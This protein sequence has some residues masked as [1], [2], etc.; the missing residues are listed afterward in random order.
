MGYPSLQACVADLRRHGMLTVIDTP[1]DPDQE[2]AAILRRVYRAGGPALLFTHARGCRFPL[3][4]NLYGTMER[5]RFLFRDAVE[6]V[7]QLVEMRGDPGALL[8]RPLSAW[9]AIPAA[10]HALPLP[11]PTRRAPVLA[12][13]GR[14]SDLPRVRT[15]PRD[16]GAFITLPAVY[17]EDPD[18]RGWMRSNLG[19]YRVQ[20]D[21]GVYAP[22][23][24]V[25]MHYQIHRGIG[26]HHAHAIRRGE[27]LRVHIYAGGPPSL[28]VSAVMPLPEGLPEIAFAGALGG[29]N[30]RISQLPN[31]SRGA[32]P[33]LADA[34]FLI[35]GTIDPTR[36]LPEGPFGDHLG[37]YSLVHDF[38]VMEVEAVYHRADA[39]WPF[40]SV[41]R[42]P[43]ED[44]TFGQF[45]H[46][47]T[48]AAIPAVLP[49]VKSVH[50]VDAAGVHPLL[51]VLGSERY[52]PYLERRAPQELLTQACAVLGQ[53]QLS[54]AKYVLIAAH[55]D[56]PDL[57]PHDVRR[58]LGHV[59]ARFDPRRDLHFHTRTTI[60]TLDYTGGALNQ[61]SKLVIA[62]AGPPLRTLGDTL[63]TALSLPDGFGDARLCVP[64]VIAVR[65]PR[66][67]DPHRA[68]DRVAADVD[69]LCANLPP[70]P[71]HPLV[72]LVDDPDFVSAHLDNLLWTVFT[73]SNPAADVHGRNAAVVQKHWGCEGPL[74]IDAR[75]RPH[76]A[77]A[78]EEDPEAAERVERLARSGGPL[79]GLW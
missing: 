27:K 26:V 11:V 7:T 64:G 69:A 17:T 25:G 6:G 65:G 72:V 54:L 58:F 36:T 37:Y 56:A 46:A 8:R 23:R 32:L 3:L 34:D 71:D 30:L 24:E 29:R 31:A 38:P 20:L 61:G 16:G 13:R 52:T 60:D 53:G 12:R 28:A 51:L 41:G 9:R 59:L 47:L 76:H 19:M 35:V 68:K 10:M 78:L 66:A 14:L 63:P 4:T 43:Q 50:A 57:D 40:T 5:A 39:I 1:V 22:E 67:D 77:P 75:A 44:T 42:P 48:G 15:W 45:V 74:V 79:H 73:R 2:V 21:G 33:V 70:L 55:E 18:A 62:A 49:G